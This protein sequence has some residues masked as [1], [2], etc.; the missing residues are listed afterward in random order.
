MYDVVWKSHHR[1]SL[2]NIFSLSVLV[3]L[4]KKS[5]SY[6]TLDKVTNQHTTCIPIFTVTIGLVMNC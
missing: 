5:E 4:G 3:S 1:A 2:F 6:C